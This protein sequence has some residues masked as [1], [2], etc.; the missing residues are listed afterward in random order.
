MKANYIK[1]TYRT[2]FDECQVKVAELRDK[3]MKKEKHPK[4]VFWLLLTTKS[5]YLAGL[6]FELKRFDMTL[7]EL[8]ERAI[9]ESKQVQ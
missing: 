5:K 1:V 8:R 2:L 6:R 3:I 7:D 4:W 9:S